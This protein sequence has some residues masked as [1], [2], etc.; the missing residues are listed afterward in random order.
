MLWWT[1]LSIINNVQKK[2]K[3]GNT[4]TFWTDTS[5]LIVKIIK[6]NKDFDLK[7]E[8]IMYP[9]PRKN[10]RIIYF[11]FY[12]VKHF[13]LLFYIILKEKP[14][15]IYSTGG[16]LTIPFFFA[17]RLLQINFHLYHLDVIPGKAA[18]FISFF[19]PIQYTLY[20]ETA[21]YLWHKNEIKKSIYP[22]RYTKE[23]IIPSSIAKIKLNIPAEKKVIFILGG[24][25]GSTQ[26]NEIIHS[27]IENNNITNYFFIHQTGYLQK[28]EMIDFYKKKN[29]EGILFDFSNEV[30]CYFNAADLI[31]SRAGAG[32]IAEILFFKKKALLVP[33]KGI[34][35]NHQEK[36]AFVAQKYNSNI[37]IFLSQNQIKQLLL[38]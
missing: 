12:S 32:T 2:K 38:I 37:S 19:K 28:K 26:I 8:K 18:Q 30:I 22:V 24:S 16:Y 13:I 20:K 1:C 25:Q 5:D 6:D 17:A 15:D 21:K 33:L 23:D 27:F 29:V 14:T 35:S 3:A 11:I 31:I 34:A 4:Y 36:N 10:Y 9:P 7:H